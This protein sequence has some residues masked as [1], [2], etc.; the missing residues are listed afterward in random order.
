MA[1][2]LIINTISINNPKTTAVAISS[3]FIKFLLLYIFRIIQS[4]FCYCRPYTIYV[5]WLEWCHHISIAFHDT[6][7]TWHKATAFSKWLHNWQFN[8]VNS[9][10]RINLQQLRI[11]ATLTSPSFKAS[12]IWSKHFFFQKLDYILYCIRSYMIMLRL[13]NALFRR[14]KDNRRWASSLWSFI[15]KVMSYGFILW[16]VFRIHVTDLLI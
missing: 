9:T 2:C 7:Y 6:V 5:S 3:S 4:I 16:G 12:N 13:C 14:C 10:Q 15:S 1:I 8:R 11:L